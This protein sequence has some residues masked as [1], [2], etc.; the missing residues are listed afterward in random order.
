VWAE[1]L[2]EA[3]PAKRDELR[4]RAHHAAWGRVLGGVHFPSDI[5]AGRL[6]AQAYVAECRK[7]AAFGEAF[8]AC[9]QELVAAAAAAKSH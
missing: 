6:L 7:S 9:K 2:S 3:V 5:V 1:L 4:M 8:D